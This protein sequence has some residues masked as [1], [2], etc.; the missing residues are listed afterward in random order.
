V[1]LG[2]RN[3]FRLFA[4]ALPVLAFVAP[5]LTFGT[6]LDE[7]VAAPDSNY[8]Y[9][10]ESVDDSEP[11]YTCYVLDMTSQAWRSSTE[12]NRT[13]WQHWLYVVVPATVSSERAMLFISS[14]NNGDDPAT[15]IFGL[16]SGIATY[17]NSVVSYL[18]Q[19]P[20]QPLY[21][22]DETHSR[23][24]DAIIAYSWDKFLNGGDANWPA[25]LP[26]VKSAVRAM[27]T[28]QDFCASPQRGEITINDFVVSGASKRGWTTWL[29]AA[30]DSRAAAIV[31]MVIDLLNM[32]RSF[33]HHHAAYGFWAPAVHDYEEMGIFGWF[34][35]GEMDSLLEIVDP[36]EYSDRLTM[37]KYMVNS[38]GDDFFLPDSSWFYF[39]DLSGE[40]YL[41]YIPNTN[42]S[43]ENSDALDS[44]VLFYQAILTAA[45]LPQFTWTLEDDG[46][47]RLQTVDT[48]VQVNLWQ[49]TNPTARDFRLTTIGDAWTSTELTNQ[50]GGV[51]VGQ[52]PQPPAGWTAF[53]VEL[54]YNSGQLYPYKFT[55]GV[56][57]VPAYLPFA[58]DFNFDGNVDLTDLEFLTSYWLQ[59]EPASDISPPYGDSITNLPDFAEFANHWLD[60]KP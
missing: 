47:I 44:L 26:M 23:S 10:I 59:N 25:Q 48:P 57:V 29:T 5:Q 16:L 54:I 38:A 1:G 43:L 31:P 39:D 8:T 11:N 3:I 46:S 35:T 51:Y 53:F 34:D 50:E 40:K 17:T 22:T 27:D 56:S 37:P 45:P 14:G 55:T 52:V 30:V 12:V 60:A 24:E 36:Y 9:H 19:V 21:F 32:E 7:Y 2:K 18:E 41:R 33:R 15:Y 28:V 4:A 58:C 42:H 13:L 20:N 49:A 6:A